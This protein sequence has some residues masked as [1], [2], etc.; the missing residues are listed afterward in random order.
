MIDMQQLFDDCLD[1]LC[2]V[3]DH[4][5][6]ARLCLLSRAVSNVAARHLYA[7]LRISL[8]PKKAARPR[9]ASP[10]LSLADLAALVKRHGRSVKSIEYIDDYGAS[11]E[12]H[13]DRAAESFL[14]FLPDLPALSTF[15]W[16]SSVL[17]SNTALWIALVQ[18]PQLE[19]FGLYLSEQGVL[20]EAAYIEQVSD[21]LVS[22]KVPFDCC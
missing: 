14:S 13:T 17:P 15:R 9:R 1:S 20:G 8:V 21:F 19:N 22:A 4:Q 12:P 10:I 11:T 3:A 7:H 6:L 16:L 5:T 2:C 18:S